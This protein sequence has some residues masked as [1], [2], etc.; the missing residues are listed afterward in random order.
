[1][2]HV[3]VCG[4][5]VHGAVLIVVIADGAVEEMVDEDT[6]EGFAL[7]GVGCL[8]LGLDGEAAGDFTRAGSRE[9]PVDFDHA[10]IAGADGTKLRVVTD[11]RDF[12][13][14]VVDCVDQE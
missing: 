2:L 4:G 5:V 9:L 6:I 10:G 14:R 1:M 11:L 3:E 12:R 7:C 13:V 8:G